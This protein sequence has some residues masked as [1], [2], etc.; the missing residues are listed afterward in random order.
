[1]ASPE[2]QELEQKIRALKL[3]EEALQKQAEQQ[4]HIEARLQSTQDDVA[5]TE[6]AN[7]YKAKEL[8]EREQKLKDEAR[9]I[10]QEREALITAQRRTGSGEKV[11]SS[12]LVPILLAACIVAGY[13]AFD[14]FNTNERYFAQMATASRNIDKL[15]NALNMTQEDVLERA[16]QLASKKTELMKTKTMLAELKTTTEKL[17]LEIN[18]LKGNQHTTVAERQSLTN[19]AQTLSAQLADLRAQLEDKYLTNDINEAFIDYQENDLRKL[20]LAL[21]AQSESSA[22]KEQMLQDREN[23]IK[24]LREQNARLQQELANDAAADEPETRTND[25]TDSGL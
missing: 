5:E 20:Q 15:A 16:D 13:I 3:K 6:R 18:Q 17:Q 12:L 10:K 23:Q 4:Q 25:A 8:I 1:M 24:T 11:R 2:E 7:R 21:K 19:S 14:H 9:L 22:I